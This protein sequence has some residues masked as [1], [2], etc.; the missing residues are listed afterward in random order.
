MGIC[1]AKGQVHFNSLPCQTK[2]KFVPTHTS[3]NLMFCLIVYWKTFKNHCQS[4]LSLG[5]E[6]YFYYK[7]WHNYFSL[8]PVLYLGDLKIHFLITNFEICTNLKHNFK[9][10]NWARETA[11]AMKHLVQKHEDLLCTPESIQMGSVVVCAHD[12]PAVEGKAGVSGLT[13][14]PQANQRVPGI[15]W[16]LVLKIR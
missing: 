7:R 8:I 13:G 14:Q 6:L 15:L 16:D 12:L 1:W 9:N 2:Y 5:F 11:P 4:S 3:A 10:K